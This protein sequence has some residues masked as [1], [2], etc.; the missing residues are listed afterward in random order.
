MSWVERTK[1]EIDFIIDIME[2]SGTERILDQACGFGRHAIE[3]SKRGFSAVGVDITAD[4]ITEAMRVSSLE[5]LNVEFIC[6]DLRDVSFKNEFDVVL[7]MADGAIGYLENDDENLKIF[8][9]IASSLGRVFKFSVTK[10]KS[11]QYG[12]WPNKNQQVFH[13]A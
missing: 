13:N 10:V 5:N 2:L 12:A 1:D 4:Y 6:G 8:D 9:L 11:Q 7:N 3:L